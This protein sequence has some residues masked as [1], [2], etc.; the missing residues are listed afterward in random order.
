MIAE[1]IIQ[2]NAKDLNRVFDYKIPT[3]YEKNALELIGAKVL[4]PFARRKELE[5]GYIVNIKENTQ[6]EV[7]EIAK[8]E[9]KYLKKEKIELAKWMAKRYFCNIA[10][11]LKLMLPPGSTRKINNRVKEKSINFVALKKDEDEIEIG[12]ETGKIKSQKQIR[13]LKFLLENGDSLISD[14]EMFADGSRAIVNTLCK[15]GYTEII[16]KKIERDPFEFKEIEK[17]V[18]LKLTEEQERAYNEVSDS[19]DDMLFSEFLLYG[20]TGSRKNRNLFTIN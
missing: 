16:E 5:E 2:T 4:I 17:T 7:K 1:V 18:K 19:M 8:I 20:V 12:I 3:E 14:I 10:D 13:I 6:Y 11:C 9:E 15:N